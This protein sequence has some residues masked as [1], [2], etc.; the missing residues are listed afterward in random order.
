M[1]GSTYGTHRP[2]VTMGGVLVRA[3]GAGE[4][5]PIA[6]TR[7]QSALVPLGRLCRP[8]NLSDVVQFLLSPGAEFASGEVIDL[9]GGQV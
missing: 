1:V 5:R 2:N 9:A 6:R 7:I 8:E 3:G 4:H